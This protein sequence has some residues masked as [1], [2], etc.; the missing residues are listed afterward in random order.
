[1]AIMLDP[2]ITFDAIKEETLMNEVEVPFT[3]YG[4]VKTVPRMKSFYAEFVGDAFPL[5]RYAP[6]IE[7][8][9][10]LTP[11]LRRIVDWIEAEFGQR[12][13]H[14][15]VNRYR[16]GSDHIGAHHD[17]PRDMVPG[18]MIFTLSLG[19]TRRYRM[20]K[21]TKMHGSCRY[22]TAADLAAFPAQIASDAVPEAIEFDVHDR[23][24]F[25]LDSLSNMVYKHAIKK[26]AG[27]KAA[28]A[29]ERISITLRTMKHL[30][31]AADNARGYT[32]VDR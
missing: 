9:L 19:A 26:V 23:E 2:S 15:V 31:V 25:A 28:A 12:C 17:K 21:Q 22:V 7:T 27:K 16:D 11:L 29:G 30:A 1:M 10:P 32:I 14:I 8:P 6:R 24:L 4:K 18:S 13:N 20:D 5:Y 3:I